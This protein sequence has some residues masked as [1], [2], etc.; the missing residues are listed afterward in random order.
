[1]IPIKK[2]LA[3]L[4]PYSFIALLI[5]FIIGLVLTSIIGFPSPLPDEPY[6]L[7][8]RGVVS[9]REYNNAVMLQKI[10]GTTWT[11]VVI[12]TPLN[13]PNWHE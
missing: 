9:E 12:T 7:R 10:L 8:Y 2:T 1:M 5:I 11:C 13:M 6:R 3:I 4:F